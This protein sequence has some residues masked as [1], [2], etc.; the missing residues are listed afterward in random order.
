MCFL[1]ESLKN[2]QKKINKKKTPKQN[3]EGIGIGY[4]VLFT[5]S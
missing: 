4:N 3:C 2:T 1:C 5:K